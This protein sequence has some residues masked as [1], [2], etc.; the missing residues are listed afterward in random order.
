MPAATTHCDF[1]KSVYEALPYS[2][3]CS[4]SNLHMFWLGSQ[5]P[6]LFFFSNAM[7]FP[8]SLKPLGSQMHKEHIRE[9]VK[10]L[11]DYSKGNPDLESYVS[12]YL[13]HYALDSTMHPIIYWASANESRKNGTSE[14][15]EHFR[16]EAELDVWMLNRQK[17]G[18]TVDKDL[19][20]TREDAKLLSQMYHAL[21]LNIYGRNIPASKISRTCFQTAWITGF[22]DG[23][24]RKYSFLEKFET[25][26][27]MDHL[28]TGMMLYGKTGTNLPIANEE[29]QPVEI[30]GRTETY[31]MEELF[32]RARRLAVKLITDPQPE[33]FCR[34]FD[35]EE[36]KKS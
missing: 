35:G 4:V 30:F 16:I 27:R 5:G 28:I 23:G 25:I 13:T 2:A 21:F 8:G 34:T 24:K 29:K 19:L 33:D 9:T 15:E 32:D 14:I 1:S 12:G 6:D 7:F 3:R 11:L 26:A 22:L 10:F 36:I 20:I 17:K 31:S 18:Y